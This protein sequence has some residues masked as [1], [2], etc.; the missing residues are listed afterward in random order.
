MGAGVDA[1][2][3]SDRLRLEETGAK[4]QKTKEVEG[5]VILRELMLF[6]VSST[7]KVYS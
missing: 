4:V 5:E 3:F 2:N 6:V 7:K 1:G